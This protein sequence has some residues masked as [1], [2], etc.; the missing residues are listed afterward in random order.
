MSD[1]SSSLIQNKSI[2]PPIR[3]DIEHLLDFTSLD[4]LNIEMDST[5]VGRFNFADF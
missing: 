5:Y 2:P 4:D 3:P 1:I